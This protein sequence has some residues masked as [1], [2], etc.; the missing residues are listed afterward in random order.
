MLTRTPWQIAWFFQLAN[1]QGPLDPGRSQKPGRLLWEV[2]AKR[3]AMWVAP[4]L[5][6]VSFWSYPPPSLFKAVQTIQRPAR[7]LHACFAWTQRLTEA[8]ALIKRSLAAACR[9]NKRKTRPHN[10][11]LLLDPPDKGGL[12]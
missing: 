2:Y 12:N 1:K 8:L 11:P 4:L 10:Y 5:F 9:I 7:H 6:V 3:L